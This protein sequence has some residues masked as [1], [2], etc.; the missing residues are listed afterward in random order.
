MRD[1]ENNFMKEELESLL[2]RE[3]LKG[4]EEEKAKQ[5]NQQTI[6]YIQRK[7]EYDNE[8]RKRFLGEAIIYRDELIRRLNI[9]PPKRNSYIDILFKDILAGPYL[10]NEMATYLENMDRQL[11]EGK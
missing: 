7:R 4:T 11:P 8:F 6:I 1:F 5:W 9:M 10:I 2:N 3:P